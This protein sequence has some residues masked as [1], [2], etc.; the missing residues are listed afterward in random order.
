MGWGSY[1]GRTTPEAGRRNAFEIRK[2]W[3]P[4]GRL[5]PAPTGMI[6]APAPRSFLRRLQHQAELGELLP[7]LVHGGLAEVLAGH[8]R[9]LGVLHEV[10]D[11][12]DAEGRHAI[13][14][15]HGELQLA[16][17]ALE[18]GVPFVH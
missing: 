4:T 17:G 14:G 10:P 1:P 9:R 15:A 7:D 8:Q 12:L 6:S 16:D 2:P 3:A 13:A 18:G 11:G 5:P